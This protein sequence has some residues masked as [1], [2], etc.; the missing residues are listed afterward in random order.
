MTHGGGGGRSPASLSSDEYPLLRLGELAAGGPL[1][2]TAGTDLGGAGGALEAA[3][4]GGGAIRVEL[5][6]LGG[7]G[8][9]LEAGGAL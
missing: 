9:I 7:G 6:K 8:G 1:D 5:D 2:G 4:G 3:L